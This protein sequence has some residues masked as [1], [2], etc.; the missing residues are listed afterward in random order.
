MNAKEIRRIS[1]IG[2]GN[3]AT[4][5]GLH[6]HICGFEIVNLLV[7]QVDEADL[8][9]A[10]AV[11]ADICTDYAELRAD[12][13]LIL[14]AV[15]D[16]AIEDVSK[17]LAKV[18]HLADILVVHTSGATPMRVLAAHNRYFGC[19]YPLQTF[20]RSREI[21]MYSVPICVAAN[22][23]DC[24]QRLWDLGMRISKKVARIDDDQRADLHVAAVLVNNFTNHLFDLAA[25]LCQRTG[26]NFDMLRPLISETVD[27]IDNLSPHE[28]QTG[29]ARRGDMTTIARHQ[30]LIA[31]QP[32]LLHLYTVLSE[33]ILKKY[34]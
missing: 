33:S 30:A 18:T 15:S 7:R 27:K 16:K 24:E 22:D 28:A 29:P 14:I 13:D 31:Q 11:S 26:V 5:L 8:A 21:D 6:L 9:F 10:N 3:V 4:H 12:T 32:D 23:A 25:E 19:F 1:I 2:A 34:S 20:S 17:E